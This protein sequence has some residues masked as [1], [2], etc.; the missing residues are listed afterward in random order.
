MRDCATNLTGES[1]EV[2]VVVGVGY[3]LYEVVVI[4]HVFVDVEEDLLSTHDVGE[5]LLHHAAAH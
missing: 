1:K 5:L 2:V 4:I 3:D